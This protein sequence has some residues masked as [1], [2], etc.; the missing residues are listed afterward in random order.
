MTSKGGEKAGSS[1]A[2]N[3]YIYTCTPG[4]SLL[5]GIVRGFLWF[6]LLTPEL[7]KLNWGKWNFLSSFEPE[8]IQMGHS[9][10]AGRSCTKMKD[11]CRHNGTRRRKCMTPK[12][13]KVCWL[14]QNYFLFAGGRGLLDRLPNWCWLGYS[15]WTGLRFHFWDSQNCN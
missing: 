14:S 11:F 5:L 6:P 7:L 13:K 8:S 3:R 9:N 10:L 2:I 4:W 15:W 1:G 12:K